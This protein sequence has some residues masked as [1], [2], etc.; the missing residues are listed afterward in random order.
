MV[1]KAV[2]F[3]TFFS[4]LN[5]SCIFSQNDTINDNYYYFDDGG[6]I[7]AKNIIKINTISIIRGDVPLFYE[8]Y[9]SDIFSIEAGL[10]ILFPYYNAENIFNAMNG[11]TGSY[12]NPEYGYSFSLQPKVYLSKESPLDHYI[13][14]QYRKR[15][16]IG[17]R[18]IYS[19]HDLVFCSGYQNLF[20][21][22]F[23][24]D[25]IMGIGMRN[26][27]IYNRNYIVGIFDCKFGVVF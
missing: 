27:E 5:I 7:G 17:Y 23:I 19:S 3:F 12:G 2:L 22:R 14:L 11:N 20:R 21:K 1:F 4:I 26:D 18:E 6:V 15:S 16:N 24:F 25:I 10:G 9:L 13:S 8:R